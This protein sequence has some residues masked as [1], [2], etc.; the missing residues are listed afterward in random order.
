MTTPIKY[1]GKH[2]HPSKD[3][4]VKVDAKTGV[5]TVTHRVDRRQLYILQDMEKNGKG[6]TLQ[7]FARLVKKYPSGGYGVNHVKHALKRLQDHGYVTLSDK[8][9]YSLTRSALDKFKSADK[10]VH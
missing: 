5:I 9:E 1:L 7:L 8:N 6:T 10:K 2:T 4:A 3:S